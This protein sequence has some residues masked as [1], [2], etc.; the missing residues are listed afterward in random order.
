[1]TFVR[2]FLLPTQHNAM[3]ADIRVAPAW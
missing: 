3:P 1:V 2:L